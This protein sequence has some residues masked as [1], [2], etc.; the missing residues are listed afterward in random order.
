MLIERYTHPSKE[1][2]KDAVKSLQA[3]ILPNNKLT[4]FNYFHHVPHTKQLKI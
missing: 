3:I 2:K 1:Q 4:K